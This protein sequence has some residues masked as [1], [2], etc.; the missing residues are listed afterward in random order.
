MNTIMK[1]FII[2]LLKHLNINNNNRILL[3]KLI[4]LNLIVKYALS[5][6]GS[7]E[8]RKIDVIMVI[9]ENKYTAN[10]N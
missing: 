2:L 3:I 4:F 9:S 10:F 7:E 1:N 6:A 8:F 5:I